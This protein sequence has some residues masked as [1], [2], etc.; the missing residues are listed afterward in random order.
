MQKENQ[1]Y[2]FALLNQQDEDVPSYPVLCKW[3]RTLER[4]LKSTKKI[5]ATIFRKSAKTIESTLV[6]NLNVQK[7]MDRHAGHNYMTSVQFYEKPHRRTDGMIHGVVTDSMFGLVNDEIFQAVV[8][9]LTQP[10]EAPQCSSSAL[11]AI[12]N[13]PIKRNES[14]SDADESNPSSDESENEPKTRRVQ[15]VQKPSN[16]FSKTVEEMFLHIWTS[17]RQSRKHLFTEDHAKFIATLFAS[18]NPISTSVQKYNEE[19]LPHL[20]LNL[21]LVR[22]KLKIL[23]KFANDDGSDKDDH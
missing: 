15:K 10:E 20:K 8:G 7:A 22:E 3:G 11:L 13:R 12:E 23:R 14:L 17:R 1:T 21:G 4:E 2:L 16:N 18:G 5:D 9:E 19:N 6:K